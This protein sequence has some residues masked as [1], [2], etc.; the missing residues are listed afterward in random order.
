MLWGECSM[1]L[2]WLRWYFVS[3]YGGFPVCDDSWSSKF[4]N[5][6]QFRE[7]ES[8][9]VLHEKFQSWG[10]GGILSASDPNFLSPPWEVQILHMCVGTN[11]TVSENSS[12]SLRA[13]LS[14]ST[15]DWKAKQRYLYWYLPAPGLA[16]SGG[17]CYAFSIV[18]SWLVLV[19]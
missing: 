18:S 14:Q 13:G 19:T 5:Q 8:C 15:F 9:R 7:I 12:G 3:C 17:I 11:M 2:T 16:P 4:I 1:F 10:G 6:E